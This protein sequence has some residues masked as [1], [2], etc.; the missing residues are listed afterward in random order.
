MPRLVLHASNDSP[1]RK[2]KNR[3]QK[4]TKEKSSCYVLVQ[5]LGKRVHCGCNSDSYMGMAANLHH[6]SI[7]LTPSLPPPPPPPHHQRRR[8]CAMT[9][10]CLFRHHNAVQMLCILSHW[11]PPKCTGKYTCC[12]LSG[13]CLV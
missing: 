1:A 8:T 2:K 7:V 6:I 4:N 9:K 13:S 12:H 11:P 3:K 5:N 10:N